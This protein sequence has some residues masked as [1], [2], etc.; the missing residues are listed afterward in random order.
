LAALTVRLALAAVAVAVAAAVAVAVAEAVQSDEVRLDPILA[1][2]AVEAA[3]VA[4][5]VAPY[6]KTMVRLS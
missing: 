3:G 5:L 2:E 6:R 1:G 4:A